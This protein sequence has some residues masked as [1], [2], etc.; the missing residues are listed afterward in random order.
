MKE[1]HKTLVANPAVVTQ[2]TADGAV[3]IEMNSGD[4]FELNHVGAE[5]WSRLS[6]GEGLANI[7]VAVAKRYAIAES[8]ADA[9]ARRLLTD[10]EQRGLLTPTK[11]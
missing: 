7:V 10:L 8:T 3:L 5:I 4:C 11:R 2:T 9:D 1:E 6:Q